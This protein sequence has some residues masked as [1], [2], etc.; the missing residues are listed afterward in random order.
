LPEVWKHIVKGH[1]E[2]E[3]Y[4]SKIGETLARPAI[5]C[6]S[7]KNEQRHLYYRFLRAKLFFV[8]VADAAKNIIITSYISDR[9]KEGDVLW[10]EKR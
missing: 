7:R 4:L 9:I 8:V 2:V 3:K 6:R 10:R 1:P 5:I